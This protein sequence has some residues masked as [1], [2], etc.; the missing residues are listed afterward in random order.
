MN[1][2][3]VTRNIQ[4]ESKKIN[5]LNGGVVYNNKNNNNINQE[6]KAIDNNI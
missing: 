2:K 1:Y 6:Q 5:Y 4:S 3:A